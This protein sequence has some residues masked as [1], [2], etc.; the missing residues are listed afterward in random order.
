[1]IK[2]LIVDDAELIRI[3]L[4]GILTKAGC[5]IVGESSSGKEALELYKQRQPDLVTLDIT[6]PGQDGIETLKQ[7]ISIGK[8]VKVIIISASEQKGLVIEA[9]R[10]KASAFILKPFEA[11]QIIKKVKDLFLQNVTHN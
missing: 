5:E 9:L 4:K 10:E 8:E 7:I 2:T 1:M 11:E 6:M 3:R